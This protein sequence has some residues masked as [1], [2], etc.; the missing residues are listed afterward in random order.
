MN[1][2][3]RYIYVYSPERDKAML[4]INCVIDTVLFYGILFIAERFTNTTLRS[5]YVQAIYWLLFGVCIV[6]AIAS[7][8]CK[9]KN[10]LR[11]TDS[12][13]NYRYGMLQQHEVI[14]PISEVRS[15]K[16][17]ASSLQ[18]RYGSSTLSIFAAGEVGK[19][20]FED[21]RDGEEACRI[22]KDL[23]KPRSCY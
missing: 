15:C 20:R 21:I 14:L 9:T 5:G 3:V 23:I 2:N 7:I 4:V 11:I 13:I 17:N 8:C 19:I 18:K 6:G 22:I 1:E 10:C 16:N 12:A